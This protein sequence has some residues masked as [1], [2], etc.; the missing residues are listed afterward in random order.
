MVPPSTAPWGAAVRLVARQY[1]TSLRRNC[2]LRVEWAASCSAARGDGPA[3]GLG[4]PRQCDAQRS[5]AGAQAD[6]GQLGRG[7]DG[8]LQRAGRRRHRGGECG[9]RAG[10]GAARARVAVLSR[11]LVSRCRPRARPRAVGGL[12]PGGRGLGAAA[13]RLGLGRRLAF[14]AGLADA[15]AVASRGCRGPLACRCGD[16]DACSAATRSRRA[17]VSRSSPQ[18]S[19]ATVSGGPVRV[20]RAIQM[21]RIDRVR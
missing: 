13:C 1:M 4:Q 3:S 17:G 9:I 12:G 6:L 5:C 10:D 11:A 19:Q 8:R 16:A 2:K 14:A 21:L 18:S 20:H 7:L 15:G